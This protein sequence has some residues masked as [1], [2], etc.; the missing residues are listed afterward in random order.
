MGVVEVRIHPA[1]GIARV[2]NSVDEYFIGPE[3]QWDRSAPADG[4]YKDRSHRIKRQVAR[5]RLFAYDERGVPTELVEGPGVEITWT[6]H[7]VN[8]KAAARL[9]RPDS[10]RNSGYSGDALRD[11]VIDPG[12]RTVDR[13]HRRAEFGTG[14]FILK[15]CRPQRVPLGEIRLDDDGRLLVFGGAGAT[16][17]PAHTSLSVQD[18]SDNWYDD[19]ADGPVTATVRINGADHPVAG[20]WV[21]TAPPNFAPPVGSAIRLWDAMFDAL[22]TEQQKSAPPSYVDDIY[23]ILQAAIDS[24]AVASVAKPHH[25]FRHPVSPRELDEQLAKVGHMPRLA[26]GRGAA[27]DL[28]LTPT[29]KQRMRVWAKAGNPDISWDMTWVDGPPVSKD[30]T[31]DGMDKA[32]LENC[33]GGALRPGIEAGEFLL[34]PARYGPIETVNGQPSFRLDHNQVEPGQVTAGMSLPW[35]ADF[36]ACNP[37]WWPAPRPGQ[38]VPAGSP[39]G[40]APVQWNRGYSRPVF[41]NGGWT[42]MGFVTRQAEGLVETDSDPLNQ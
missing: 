28:P 20:S 36:H 12:P 22:A 35:Q 24:G 4:S 39:P 8:A 7:L 31:P 25:H 19:I 17:S 2:G 18:D 3:R 30:F 33:V 32:A 27:L 34:E 42:R 41:V 37:L 9:F 38:V 21:I 11:L 13:L 26:S 6:V 14:K 1:I 40:A 16:G 29:Q 23:P 15:E 10:T 5:F